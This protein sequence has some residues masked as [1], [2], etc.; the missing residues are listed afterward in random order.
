MVN[1]RERI[2]KG[3]DSISQ[4]VYDQSGDVLFDSEVTAHAVQSIKALAPIYGKDAAPY[5][6]A[7]LQFAMQ[8]WIYE[9]YMEI[10]EDKRERALLMNSAMQFAVAQSG[11][12]EGWEAHAQDILAAAKDE[13]RKHTG[14]LQEETAALLDVAREI[15]KNLSD[16]E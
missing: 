3:G 16:D 12:G 1:G 13:V 6:A 9:P 11:I 14:D 10:F 5:L 15:K 7:A 4:A 2:E 8:Y